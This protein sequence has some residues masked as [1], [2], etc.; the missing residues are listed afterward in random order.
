MPT[1]RDI[2]LALPGVVVRRLGAREGFFTAGRMFALA[3]QRSL[4]LRLPPAKAA[5]LLV[6]GPVRTLGGDGLPLPDAW[7]E[8]P[9]ETTPPH[10]LVRLAAEAHETVRLL[11]RRAGRG[12]MI[13]RRRRTPRSA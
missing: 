5:D 1:A 7:T 11:R 2:L 6:R 9:I 13:A 8:F 12:R 4:L 3:D 10:E